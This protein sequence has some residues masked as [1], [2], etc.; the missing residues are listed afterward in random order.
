MELDPLRTRQAITGIDADAMLLRCLV[1]AMYD[2]HP[3]KAAVKAGFKKAAQG[4]WETAPPDADPEKII[5]LQARF[6][7]YL[8]MLD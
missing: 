8:D 7:F 3:N 4:L 2:A 1:L 6:P 5:E